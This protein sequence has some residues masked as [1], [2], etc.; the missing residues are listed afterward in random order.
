[1]QG[2]G[3]GGATSHASPR[4][5]FTVRRLMAAVVFVALALWVYRQWWWYRL[6]LEHERFVG[7]YLHLA[8]DDL[9]AI[10]ILPGPD[11]QRRTISADLRP[12]TRVM[13]GRGGDVEGLL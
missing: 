4:V 1:M 9:G 3:R 12:L 2:A 13:A 5:R 8:S 7:V 11:R 10:A 6:R